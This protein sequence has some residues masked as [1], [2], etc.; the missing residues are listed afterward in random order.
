MQTRIMTL[1]L[2]PTILGVLSYGEFHDE[3][4]KNVLSYSSQNPKA[5]HIGHLKQLEQG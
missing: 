4:K 2:D 1:F 3:E 5:L